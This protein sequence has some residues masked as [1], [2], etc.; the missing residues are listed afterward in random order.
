[1]PMSETE[2]ESA[3]ARSERVEEWQARAG[4]IDGGS[5]PFWMALSTLHFFTPTA[6]ATSD[7]D[8]PSASRLR[9][10]SITQGVITTDPRTS[11]GA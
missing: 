8:C 9:H 7:R 6:A 4:R 11:D 2:A 10:F 3:S 5:S 1:M